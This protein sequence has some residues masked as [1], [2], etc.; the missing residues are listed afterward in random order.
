MLRPPIRDNVLYQN[1]RS[2][3]RYEIVTPR[4]IYVRS[5]KVITIT[6]FSH[7]LRTEHP[8]RNEREQLVVH[9]HRT[10]LRSRADKRS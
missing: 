5:L 10:V 1:I 6:F 3:A 2:R 9:D 4:I 7:H 8:A